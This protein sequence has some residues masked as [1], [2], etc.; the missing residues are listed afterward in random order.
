MFCPG[1]FCLWRIVN[2]KHEQ[3]CSFMALR[4]AQKIHTL[5]LKEAM[6]RKWNITLRRKKVRVTSNL[7]I[8]WKSSINNRKTAQRLEQVIEK[9]GQVQIVPSRNV[10][11]QCNS[12]KEM[13][14]APTVNENLFAHICPLITCQE[15]SQGDSLVEKFLVRAECVHSL[16][17]T[18]HCSR[19]LQCIDDGF[20]CSWRIWN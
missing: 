14:G 6:P 16:D 13:D 9:P 15:I 4:K 3:N 5:F 7:G 2:D 17:N 19:F 20:C 10:K 8:L 1:I 12:K 11:T 18:S